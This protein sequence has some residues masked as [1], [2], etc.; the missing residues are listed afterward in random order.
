MQALRLL[1]NFGSFRK[2]SVCQSSKMWMATE[3]ELIMKT[4]NSRISKTKIT[5]NWFLC[6]IFRELRNFGNEIFRIF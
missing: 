1:T 6:E 4:I 2:K 3:K 5:Q